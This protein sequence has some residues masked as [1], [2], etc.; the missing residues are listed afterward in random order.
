MAL[1]DDILALVEQHGLTDSLTAEAGQITTDVEQ[2]RENIEQ[3]MRFIP[4]VVTIGLL[5]IWWL[6]RRFMAVLVGGAVLATVVCSALSL[7]VLFDTPFN[8]ISAI[9]PPLLSALTI[10]AL[11]HLFNAFHYASRRGIQ[12][13]ERVAFALRMPRR[14]LL[15]PPLGL[16]LR[17]LL[18]L[19]L[20]LWAWRWSSWIWFHGLISRAGLAL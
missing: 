13:A 18:E 8:L 1:Q 10:A 4:M 3:N 11:V 17:S 20:S 6:F 2:M 9:L 19:A 15:R 16:H 5:M 12:G 14:C 7:F